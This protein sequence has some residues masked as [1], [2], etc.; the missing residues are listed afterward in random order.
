[1]LWLR[2]ISVPM[3]FGSIQASTQ[4][5]GRVFTIADNVNLVLLDVAVKNSVDQYVIDLNKSSFRVYEDGHQRQL[6]EFSRVDAPCTV[7]LVVDNSGS[8][9]NKRSYIVSAGLAFAKES[10]P[11]DEFFVVNFNNYVVRGL[12]AST[13]FTDQLQQLRSALYFG[14]PEGQ[15][16]LYD[17][18][19]YS[20]KHLERGHHE[21][22][23]L[24]VVSDGRDNVSKLKFSQ[25]LRL[26]AESRATI[27]TVG[28]YDED[29]YDKNPGVLRQIAQI[30]G[31]EFFQPRSLAEVSP[32]FNQI[33]ND[34]RK[35]Y[36]IG[37]VPGEAN[38]KR[39]MRMIK[40]IAE[41]GGR[42][43]RVR[44]RRSYITVPKLSSPG[45]GSEVVH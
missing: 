40:V 24:I 32:I 4:S 29:D 5:D 21:N 36:T 42:K 35:R 31:G 2:L 38:S 14:L 1:M 45:E 19:A 13:A 9:R 34:I 10:N 8:M 17:A 18:I 11:R 41:S 16:A 15:T 37:F 39:E 30:S 33:S 22:R 6:T 20:L 28:A 12:P 27:Y 3:L 44:A 23:T 7:G 43:L 26:I 25:L